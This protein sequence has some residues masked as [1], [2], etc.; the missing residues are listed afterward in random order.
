MDMAMPCLYYG[1]PLV[2]HRMRKFDPDAA[3]R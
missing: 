2:S 3:L 1:V